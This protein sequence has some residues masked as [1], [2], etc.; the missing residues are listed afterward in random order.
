MAHKVLGVDLGSHTV[1]VVELTLGFRTV[2]A[3]A[4]YSAPVQPGDEP[5]A[6]RAMRALAQLIVQKGLHGEQRFEALGGDGLMIRL[7]SLPFSDAKKIDMVVGNELEA[8]IA[9]ETP[10]RELTEAELLEVSGGG[11]AGFCDNG[12]V[13][14]H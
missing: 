6:E 14:S 4:F 13:A 10:N 7:L 8:Q 5:V 9:E 12:M 1:K 3:T 11:L 2:Q